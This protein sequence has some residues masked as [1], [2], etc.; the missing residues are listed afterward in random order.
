MSNFD[1]WEIFMY[2]NTINYMEVKI[3]TQRGNTQRGLKCRDETLCG[4]TH[5]LNISEL[6]GRT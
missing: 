5:L 2:Y 4:L 3:N 1:I 6:I